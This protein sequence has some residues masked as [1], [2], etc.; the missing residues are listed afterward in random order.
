[1]RMIIMLA[2]L[3]AASTAQAQDTLPFFNAD[4]IM[5]GCRALPLN[6]ELLH[7]LG[8]KSNTYISGYC[9]GV[10]VGLFYLRTN[11]F[12][13]PPGATFGQVIQVVIAYIDKSERMHKD[14]DTLAF[15]ALTD[16]W[17]CNGKWG[18]IPSR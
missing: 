6:T 18:S 15:E 8:P 11:Y 7:R 1:M 4:T 5:P 2:A 17:P 13:P 12:C 14:F 9:A 16:A 10:V 3:L